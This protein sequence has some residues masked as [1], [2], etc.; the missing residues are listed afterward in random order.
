MFHDRA[1]EF[2]QNVN[3]AGR[4]ATFVEAKGHIHMSMF[5]GALKS[6]DEMH[7]KKAD[8]LKAVFAENLLPL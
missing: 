2:V 1:E 3:R 7:Q 4:K 5:E 6:A 8:T